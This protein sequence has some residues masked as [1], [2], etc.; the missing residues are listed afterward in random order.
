LRAILDPWRSTPRDIPNSSEKP[1]AISIVDAMT[2]GLT[3]AARR[4]WLA[5]IPFAL[6]LLIWLAPPL[7][8]R[9]LL[10]RLMVVWEALVRVSYPPDQMAAI[11]DVLTSMKEMAAQLGAQINLF[12]YL[13][14]SWLS[15]PSALVT[16]QSARL[17]FIS[18]MIFAPVGLS[19]RIGQIAKAPWQP[20]PVEIGNLWLAGLIVILLWLAGQLVVTFFLRWA[21]RRPGEAAADPAAPP[22]AGNWEGLRGFA[23]LFGRLVV[24]SLL[25]GA[26]MLFLRLP[27]G[28]LLTLIMLTGS[29]AGA[30][31]FAVVGGITL[32]MVLWLLT[33]L[34]FAG[35]AILLDGQSLFQSLVRS[36]SLVRTQS[37][38]TI[39]LAAAINLVVV[40]FRVVWGLVGQS[41]AGAVLAMAGNAFLCTG[42][43]LA[44]FVYYQDRRRQWEALVASAGKRTGLR[45]RMK[46]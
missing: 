16:P 43:V 19:L 23:R 9:G 10:D 31:L 24:L 13:T 45:N 6:D 8:I 26:A 42:M 14:G 21:A 3:E 7:S 39:G 5:L 2:A 32:W 29:S 17:T 40:G 33:S 35:D 11:G 41:P 20:P 25:L 34:Y 1:Q 22:V 27:L 36:V 12:H 30:L 4:P 38:A 46:D 28:F 18:D 37:L 44:I 15:V